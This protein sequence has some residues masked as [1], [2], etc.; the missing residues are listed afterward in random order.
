MD[1]LHLLQWFPSRPLSL[2]RPRSHLPVASAA[3][4]KKS[5]L[6]PDGA[7]KGGWVLK[8]LRVGSLF[9]E[10]EKKREAIDGALEGDEM[11]MDV[12]GDDRCVD[13]GCACGDEETTAEFDRESFSRLLRRAS[14]METRLYAKMSYLGSLAYCIPRIKP[15]NL[16]RRHGLRFVT[17]SFDKK[18]AKSLAAEKE[19]TLIQ[20]SKPKE[21][22]PA[23]ATKECVH[24]HRKDREIS[25]SAAYHIAASAAGYLQSQTRGFLHLRSSNVNVGKDSPELGINN[26]GKDEENMTAKMASFIATKDSVTA[27]VAGKEE[28]KQALAN[29][30]SSSNSSPCEWYIC[31]DDHSGTRYF[32]IQGSETLG[33]WQANLLF[34]PIE[35][36]G[37]D[38][39][40][41]R[42]IYEAAKGIYSQILPEVRQ[43]LESH[44]DSATFRFTGHSLGGSLSMLINLML[45]IRGEAPVSSLLPTVTFGA[46]SIMCGGDYLLRK[47][48]LPQTHVQ[49]VMLHRDIVPR[50]FSCIYPDHVV[51]ILKAINGNFRHHPCLNKKK[52]LYAPMGKL[53]ILQPEDKFSPQ[54]HLL[55]AGSGL[56]L[57]DSNSS[58][59]CADALPLLQSAWFA[60]L[61][62]PH[63][64]EILI[65][66]NAY[67]SR[68]SV[69][70]DHDVHGY[71]K[72]LQGVIHQELRFIRTANRKQRRRTGLSSKSFGIYNVIFHGGKETLKRLSKLITSQSM[73]I[74]VI[75]L[76]P[77]GLLFSGALMVAILV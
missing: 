16:L 38:V 27:M 43:H 25:A 1:V 42:G 51:D 73:Q 68:G 12:N 44:G 29:D 19:G 40:V 3:A 57:L 7:L 41:H 13:C 20:D 60:F 64:L 65:D 58:A 50:A 75:L 17:S 66:R 6:P 34:E 49:S 39:L 62:T 22:T 23:T 59:D 56:F 14:L 11:E 71:L 33:S 26:E 63:P 18:E 35:F 47:L 46:P 61:N 28:M 69:M 72:S 10:G 45:L 67:G 2:S 70:R 32:V 21:K 76:V 5:A 37:M 9:A 15:E 53:W 30:L 8:I 48:G 74:L 4:A 24:E 31:D 55:P 36:E 77:I 54:H 52:L